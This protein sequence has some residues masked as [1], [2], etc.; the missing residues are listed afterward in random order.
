LNELRSLIKEG[1]RTV[2]WNFIE[3][4]KRVDDETVKATYK[5]DDMIICGTNR[6]KDYYTDMF[7]DL[8]KWYVNKNTEYHNN[9]DIIISE[10]QPKNSVIRHAFTAHSIQ[11]ETAQ[12]MLFINSKKLE[13]IRGFYTAVS[14]AKTYEQIL[15]I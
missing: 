11:G 2:P 6:A 14:R 10:E 7:K 4:F 3:K 15:V 8:K 12:N 13:D 9:G 1:Y 5:I